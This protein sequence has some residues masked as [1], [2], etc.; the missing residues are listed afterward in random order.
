MANTRI[1]ITV[2]VVVEVIGCTEWNEMECIQNEGQHPHT[3]NL[4]LGSVR[5][6][7]RTNHGVWCLHLDG[8]MTRIFSR[9]VFHNHENER[10]C[11]LKTIVV[12][13]ADSE[14]D[15]SM[16]ALSCLELKSNSTVSITAE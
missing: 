6:S 13:L 1:G 5:G 10:T 9:S 11:Q 16:V 3:H 7:E 8:T 14:C 12:V 15:I 2:V 4:A